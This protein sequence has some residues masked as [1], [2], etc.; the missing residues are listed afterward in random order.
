MAGSKRQI[1][2]EVMAEKAKAK[3]V[4][5]VHVAN[6]KPIRVIQDSPKKKINVQYF[7][8]SGNL[9]KREM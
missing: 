7:S 8:K 4:S 9:Q 5:P 1:I 3:G 6:Q 2:A